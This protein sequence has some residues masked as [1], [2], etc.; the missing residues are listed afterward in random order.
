M[1]YPIFTLDISTNGEMLHIYDAYL[2]LVF[3]S[4]VFNFEGILIED[5]GKRYIY[6]LHIGKKTRNQII[7]LNFLFFVQRN[8]RVPLFN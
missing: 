3:I 6:L 2:S 8:K 1:Q 4:Q 7:Y 5:Q